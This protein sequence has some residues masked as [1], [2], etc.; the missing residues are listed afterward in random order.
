MSKSSISGV[1][2]AAASNSMLCET[3]VNPD[4]QRRNCGRQV[5]HAHQIVGRAS[6]G[7]DPIYF[8]DPA[9]A[10]FPHQRNR[11]QPAKAFFDPLPLPLAD[12]VTRVPRRAPINRARRLAAHGSAPRAAPHADCGTRPQTRA[13]QTLCRHPPSPTS[14]RES[15]QQHQSRISFRR[16][17]GLENSRLHDQSVAVLHQKIPAVTQLGLFA[18]AFARQQRL[19]ITLRCRRLIRPL[20]T[21]KVYGGLPGSSGGGSLPLLRLKTLGTRPRFHQRAIHREML[22]G[23]QTFRPRLLHHPRQKLFR[24]IGLQQAVAILG[25][26]VAS[27]TSSSAFSPTNQRNSRL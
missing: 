25:E 18:V 11:L 9:M 4:L 21:A 7:E 3:H 8:A 1:F 23:R 12:G 6:E 16:S 13:C 5:S 15:F 10:H 26:P 27:Q 19:G 22:V 2:V 17:V 20:L 24:Y 14:F